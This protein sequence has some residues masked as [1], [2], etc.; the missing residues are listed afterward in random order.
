MAYFAR[1]LH[2]DAMENASSDVH[3]GSLAAIG[4]A[5]RTIRLEKQISQEELAHISS[6]DRSHLGRIER[7]ERNL[8]ILNLLRIARALGR[9]PSEVLSRAGL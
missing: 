4:Q 5:I 1:K 7:G 3:A 9:A 8:S 2:D 6:L